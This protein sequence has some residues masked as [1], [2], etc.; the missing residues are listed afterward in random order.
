VS[1]RAKG[2]VNVARIAAQ[3]GGGGHPNAA[4]A[5][6]RASLEEARTR[7]LAAARAALP[8]PP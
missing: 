2:E 1:L 5:I 3:F 8:G 4:G 6:V 7:V